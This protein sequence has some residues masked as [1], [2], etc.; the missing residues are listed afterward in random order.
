MSGFLGEE[1]MERGAL[2]SAQAFFEPSAGT[3]LCMHQAKPSRVAAKM[4][5]AQ[6]YRDQ[7]SQ[8][9]GNSSSARKERDD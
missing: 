5:G 1:S 6:R 3:E 4:R 7:E 8:R 9:C 2:R